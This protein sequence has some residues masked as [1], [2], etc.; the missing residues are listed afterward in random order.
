MG[1][2]GL[3][4]GG[5][6]GVGQGGVGLVGRGGVGLPV[7]RSHGKLPLIEVPDEDEDD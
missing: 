7:I 6:V 3:G 2:V 5:G 1:L 4:T